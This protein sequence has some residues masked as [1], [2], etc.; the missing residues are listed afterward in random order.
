MEWVVTNIFVG[1]LGLDATEEQLRMLFAVYGTV[2]TVTIVKDRDT[3]EP[4]GFAF[5]EMTQAEQAQ[6]A[7][8]S[9]NS[10]LLNERPLRVNEARPKLHRDPTRDLGNRDHRRHQI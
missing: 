3:L 4:R 2:E 9:L 6:A 7:I 1:N 5:V 10:K 8:S